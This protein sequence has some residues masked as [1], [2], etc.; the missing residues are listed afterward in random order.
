MWRYS[1]SPLE[2][3]LLLSV[4]G[5][6][7]DRGWECDG[8]AVKGELNR[9]LMKRCRKETEE[10]NLLKPTDYILRKRSLKTSESSKR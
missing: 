3:E 5:M 8:R 6:V 10:K 9:A 7:R 1:T 2:R 4:D